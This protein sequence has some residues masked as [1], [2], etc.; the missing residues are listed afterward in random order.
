MTG[1]E[2]IKI[3]FDESAIRA[4]KHFSI[5]GKMHLGVAEDILNYLEGITFAVTMAHKEKM[6]DYD[7]ADEMF[8]RVHN[9]R[10][11]IL[12]KKAETP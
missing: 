6:S 9:L 2:R 10:M 12:N 4:E 5:G 7:L 8:D 3:V 11:K 1:I